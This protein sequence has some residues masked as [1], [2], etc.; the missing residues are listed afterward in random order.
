MLFET[1]VSVLDSEDLSSKDQRQR[2]VGNLFT[3]SPILLGRCN[4]YTWHTQTGIPKP[5]RHLFLGR[6]CF[7]CIVSILGFRFSF[8]E[9]DLE[10]KARAIQERLAS[11][12]EESIV[13]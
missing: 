11:I 10:G 9:S 5:S 3:E 13:N 4:F 12:L 1:N 8:R 6:C 2:S 7:G